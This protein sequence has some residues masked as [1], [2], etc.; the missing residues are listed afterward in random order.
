MRKF[1]ELV[2]EYPLS[3]LFIAMFITNVLKIIF[4]R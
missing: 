2:D 4:E 1:F 3:A